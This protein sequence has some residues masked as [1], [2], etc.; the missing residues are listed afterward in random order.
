MRY[1]QIRK[2]DI[3]NGEGV[4]VSLYVQGCHRH[5]LNCFNP[6]TWDFS[7]GK[8]FDIETENTLI[9]LVNQPHIIGITILGGEPLESENREDIEKLLKRLRR[10]C[11]NKTIWLY[12]SFLYEEIKE[13][14]ED[15]L[16]NLDILVDGPFIEELKDRKLRFRGSSNQRVI[17]VQTT[18]VSNKITLY[19]NSRYYQDNG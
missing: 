19:Q 10:D 17:D 14:K 7:G 3:A 11:P 15:I 8:D 4:R 5:C 13:F 9:N 1:A 18:L 6:E 16:S 2:L 12:S